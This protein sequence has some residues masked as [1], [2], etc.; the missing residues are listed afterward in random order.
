MTISKEALK[1]YK[2]LYPQQ[3]NF[4][5]FI[6][7]IDGSTIYEMGL[8]AV[9]SDI[10]PKDVC[11]ETRIGDVV[12][13]RPI[14][15]AAMDT[16]SG[17]A[18]GIGMFK[19][20]GAS[21]TFRYKD[22]N[23]Q[24]AR[25]ET[26]LT[27]KPF[28]VDKPMTLRPYDPVEK[29]QEIIDEHRYSTIPI[30]GDDN[31]LLGILFTRG[32]VFDQHYGDPVKN[33]MKPISELET[34]SLNAPFEKI[35]DTMLNKRNT[36]AVLPVIDEDQKFHGMYFKQDFFNT[37]PVF[38]KDKPLVGMAVGVNADDLS[39]VAEAVDLGTGIIVIDSSHGSCREV[40]KQAEKIVKIVNRRAA[41]IAGNI[42]DI[43]G[44][45]K[46]SE[47]GVD[48]VKLFIGSGSI[49][50]T[51][52][53]T[54]IAWPTWQSIREMSFVRLK[55]KEKYK[56]K[57]IPVL[58]P[59][60]GMNTCGAITVALGAGGHVCMCGEYL[61]GANESRS[62]D[63]GDTKEIDGITYVKY[64]GMASKESI[65]KQMSYRY[66]ARKRASEGIS[67]WVPKKGPLQKWIGDDMELI[68]GGFAHTGSKNIEELH[69]FGN[70]PFV[71]SRFSATGQS[72]VATRI[73]P[74]KI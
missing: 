67:G 28:L 65:K 70:L 13:N 41:V 71:W 51:S 24:L 14:I 8:R 22:P 46:L 6:P 18:M 60:G 39:R 68:Q 2:M 48:G 74:D 9:E 69:E 40:Y 32:V 20:G 17:K 63:I 53:G 19:I 73:I 21:I 7:P 4:T 36:D 31:V 55:L 38:Y 58:I 43:D 64:R 23:D 72:Q 59:D 16:V 34:I 11:L 30:V 61:V 3:A 27:H 56:N 57:R 42:I 44:F 47:I 1:Y 10:E 54:G 33:W 25:L 37:K 66:G 29:A 35:K 12:L 49:C 5:G 15:S 50:T 52:T 62:Y 26:I 45:L